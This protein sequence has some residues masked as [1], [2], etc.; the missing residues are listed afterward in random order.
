MSMKNPL[1][2]YTISAL[3]I[4]SS[5]HRGGESSTEEAGIETAQ[6]GEIVLSRTQFETSGMKV[7]APEA[8]LFSN[9]INANGY[10]SASLSG[11]AKINTLIAGRVRQVYHSVGDQVKKGD[12]LFLLESYEIIQLQQDYAELTYQLALLKADYERQKSLSDEKIVAQKEFNKTESDYRSMLAR[13]GGLKARLKLINMD[14]ASV[15][16]GNIVS[17]LTVRSPIRGVV[18]SQELVLGQFIEPQLTV[19]EVVDTRKLQLT[20]RVFERDLSAL[21]IGQTVKFYTPDQPELVYE[22][23][24][25]HIGKSLDPETKTV[26]CLARIQ[27]VDR[28]VFVNM[29]YVETKVITCQREALAIPENALIREPDRDFIWSMVAE[30]EDQLTFRKIPVQTGPTRRGFTEILDEDLTKI[31]LEGAFMLRV[32]D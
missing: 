24:L 5:C 25:S 31:L 22:A 12:A 8:M 7:G 19:M 16:D 20:L 26:Q 30:H 17:V 27:A 29:L 11:R 4:V 6:P 23:T 18:T 15:E 28:G 2:I 21:V 1:L 3:I 9:E 14:P 13:A 10:L 32:E